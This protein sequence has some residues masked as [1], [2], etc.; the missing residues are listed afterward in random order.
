MSLEVEEASA[1]GGKKIGNYEKDLFYNG[2]PLDI[3][4]DPL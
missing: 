3:K 2:H 1:K 4:P